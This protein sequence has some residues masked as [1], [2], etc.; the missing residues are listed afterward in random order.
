MRNFRESKGAEID[1]GKLIRDKNKTK[2]FVR[3]L[4]QNK[5]YTQF[6]RNFRSPKNIYCSSLSEYLE[7]NNIIGDFIKKYGENQ[8]GFD[9]KEKNNLFLLYSIIISN[10]FSWSNTEEKPFFWETIYYNFQK[11]VIPQNKITYQG[12]NSFMSLK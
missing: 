5:V 11:K 10:A 4:K 9:V 12:L 2:L 6:F 1:I 3:F 8:V 7:K